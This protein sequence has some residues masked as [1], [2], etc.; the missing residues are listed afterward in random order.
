MYYLQDS[1]TRLKNIAVTINTDARKEESKLVFETVHGNAIQAFLDYKAAVTELNWI[2]T[3]PDTQLRVAASTMAILERNLLD[4]VELKPLAQAITSLTQIFADYEE[5]FYQTD[6]YACDYTKRLAATNTQF[7]LEYL[8]Q[9]AK[10]IKP[11]SRSIKVLN[12]YSKDG[13]NTLDFAGACSNN[14]E[15]YAV[16]TDGDILSSYKSR[17]HRIALGEL[18][19]AIISNDVFDIVMVA[20]PVSLDKKGKNVIEKT[21][22]DYLQKSM[23]YLR[24]GGLLLYSIPLTHL[25]REICTY[26]A[27][28][29]IDVQI[30]ITD[31]N[32]C[33]S[34]YRNTDRER[35]VDSETNIALRTLI[36]HLDDEKYYVE[37]DLDEFG[38]PL[39]A[40]SVQMFRGHRLDEDEFTNMFDHSSATVGFWEHQ[41]V[42]KLS[43]NTKT[44]LLPFNVGQLGLILTSGCLDGVVDEG[45][46]FSHAV[47]GRVIKKCNT[48][49]DISSERRTIDYTEVTSN[50][51]EINTFLPD[52]TY[53]CLA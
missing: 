21:E 38:L 3:D 18:K 49:R 44:P 6:L 8:R 22:R 39:P 9:V 40:E 47:K 11:M 52:G 48:Q 16:D 14:M 23:N 31:R 5:K 45:N 1:V 19:G 46:G 20:P 53:R 2:L 24:P 4:V 26:L 7:D 50:R 27:K 35:S 30:R 37:T 15:L 32:V 34:G 51:V 10:K 42:E 33:V 36:L 43:E 13:L 28:N 29:L 17:F 41:K 12:T 25:Y